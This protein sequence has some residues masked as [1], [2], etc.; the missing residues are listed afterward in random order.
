MFP[1]PQGGRGGARGGGARAGEHGGSRHAQG[2]L[3]GRQLPPEGDGAT[4]KPACGRVVLRST[5][6]VADGGGPVGLK[7]S[8]T[9]MECPQ[10]CDPRDQDSLPFSAH[11]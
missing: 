4:G 1:L 8:A 11:S 9:R 5:I 2:V 3:R 6:E 7:V 10:R